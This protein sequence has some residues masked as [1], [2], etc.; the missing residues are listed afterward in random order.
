MDSMRTITPVVP[1]THDIPPGTGLSYPP[2]HLTHHGC[3]S[4]CAPCLRKK[5]RQLCLGLFDAFRR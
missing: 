3:R 5:R 4:S 2:N 1:T